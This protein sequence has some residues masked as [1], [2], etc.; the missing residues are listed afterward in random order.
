MIFTIVYSDNDVSTSGETAPEEPVGGSTCRGA[1]APFKGFAD[2]YTDRYNI[3]RSL[4][5]DM[6]SD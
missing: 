6:A 1:K 3:P 2:P 4:M 5:N